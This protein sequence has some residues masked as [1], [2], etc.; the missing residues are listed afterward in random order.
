MFAPAASISIRRP[1]MLSR[2][3]VPAPTIL[4]SSAASKRSA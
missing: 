2:R 4:T 3:S 1:A